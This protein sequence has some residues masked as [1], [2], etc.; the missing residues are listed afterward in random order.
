MK[1]T[2]VALLAALTMSWT[3]EGLA[4]PPD[5]APAHGWRK[6]H[7]PYV[8]YTGTKWDR[9]YDVREG[10]C[11]RNAVGAV[12]GGIAGAAIGSQVGDGDGRTVAIIVGAALGA[13][14]GARIE[15]ALDDGDRAC[16]GH[17]LEIGETGRSVEWK[18]SAT[19][20]QY[21]L[22]P[23]KGSKSGNSTCRNFTLMAERDGRKAS[24]QALACQTKQGVWQLVES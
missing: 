1:K 15:R 24:Q 21:T 20:V 6:K 12:L 10:H 2:A 22:V 18:N 8:G 9:D 3:M 17:A 5:H 23:G 11:D 4:D 7:D 14:I 19:G 13:L 16:M